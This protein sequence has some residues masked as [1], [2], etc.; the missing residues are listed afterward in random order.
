MTLVNPAGERLAF[1]AQTRRISELG[2]RKAIESMEN[3]DQSPVPL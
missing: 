3:Y 2:G 1:S